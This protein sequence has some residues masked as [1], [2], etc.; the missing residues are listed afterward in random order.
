MYMLSHSRNETRS[1]CEEISTT[2]YDIKSY[3]ESIRTV[4][5]IRFSQN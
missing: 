1:Q 2:D 5:V 4:I 3:N